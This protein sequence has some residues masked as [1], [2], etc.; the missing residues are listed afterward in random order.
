MIEYHSTVVVFVASG[1]E[2]MEAIII[3]DMLRRAGINVI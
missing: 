1:T 3:S 2:E